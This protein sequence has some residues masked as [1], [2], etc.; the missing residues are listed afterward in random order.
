MELVSNGPGRVGEALCGKPAPRISPGD[1]QALRDTDLHEA[2]GNIHCILTIW[3]GL[4][5]A[6]GTRHLSR[7]LGAWFEAQWV[8]VSLKPCPERPG[9]G[10]V[11]SSLCILQSVPQPAPSKPGGLCLLGHGV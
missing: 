11:A 4:R 1:E 10:F 8:P 7:A 5:S 9:Y 6:R 2:G 3:A